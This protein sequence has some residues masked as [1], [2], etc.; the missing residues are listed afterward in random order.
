[1]SLHHQQRI[2]YIINIRINHNRPVGDLVHGE[3]LA[4]VDGGVGGVRVLHCPTD[5]GD[6]EDDGRV[7]AAAQI[8]EQYLA[9][10]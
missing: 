4:E 9:V 1:M 3:R 6:F 5:E 2:Q 7:A 10:R 8:Q